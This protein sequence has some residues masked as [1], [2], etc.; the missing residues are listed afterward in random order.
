VFESHPQLA[1]PSAASTIWRYISL[2]AYLDL[3]RTGELHFAR[4]CDMED[5]WEGAYGHGNESARSKR[6]GDHYE[7]MVRMGVFEVLPDFAR[8]W[9]Y[10]NC[11]HG[12]EY[13]SAAMWDLYSGGKGVA[14]RTTWGRLTAALDGPAMVCGAQVSYSDYDAEWIPEG[15]L[16]FP[17]T[18]KRQSF[19]HEREVRLLVHEDFPKVPDPRD[20]DG[21]GA[22]DPHTDS[23]RYKRVAVRLDA[24]V[25]AVLLAPRAQPWVLDVLKDVTRAYKMDWPV[26]Q[27]DLLTPR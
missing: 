24:M 6:Y 2:E 13:E 8:R 16:L 17:L 22:I 19:A 27:S 5:P 11:W 23:P 3:L 20:P 21:P 14:V 7:S 9:T 15:N 4:A 25:E 10:L 18:H 12:S 26:T 1:E